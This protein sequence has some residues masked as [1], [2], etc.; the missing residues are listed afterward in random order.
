MVINRNNTI[1]PTLNTPK[2]IQPISGVENNVQNTSSRENKKQAIEQK[3]NN[4]YIADDIFIQQ[5]RTITDVNLLAEP[6]TEASRSENN[7]IRTGLEAKAEENSNENVFTQVF[8]R[9]QNTVAE[10]NA[11]RKDLELPPMETLSIGREESNIEPT[12]LR[13]ENQETFIPYEEYAPPPTLEEELGFYRYEMELAKLDSRERMVMREPLEPTP[14]PAFRQAF[15]QP[16][17]DDFSALPPP[18]HETLN[19]PLPAPLRFHETQ[20]DFLNQETTRLET[21]GAQP[22]QESAQQTLRTYDNKTKAPQ[23]IPQ[24][25]AENHQESIRPAPAGKETQSEPIEPP[26]P[27]IP[28]SLTQSNVEREAPVIETAKPNR[29]LDSFEQTQ[30]LLTGTQQIIEEDIQVTMQAT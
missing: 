10:Q 26:S 24:T 29:P 22:P 12:Q 25:L 5:L 21:D 14:P 18:K 16:Q 1:N 9:E 27:R 20:S 4:S 7:R 30:Q 11:P 6:T 28:P 3:S 15:A 8:E 23:V 2:K 17:D 13:N 19:A